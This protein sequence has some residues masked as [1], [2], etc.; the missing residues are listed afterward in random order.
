MCSLVA[1]SF[2]VNSDYDDSSMQIGNIKRRI[3]LSLLRMR[4]SFLSIDFLFC[5]MVVLLG[6]ALK[7]KHLPR[8]KLFDESLLLIPTVIESCQG[9]ANWAG[10]AQKRAEGKRQIIIIGNDVINNTQQQH[11]TLL[12]DAIDTIGASLLLCH[13]YPIVDGTKSEEA[14]ATILSVVVVFVVRR[15]QLLIGIVGFV[16]ILCSL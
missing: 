14:A 11:E 4:V 16:I 8:K 7:Q 5:H 6:R 10:G 15:K 9:S 3:Q 1:P 12:D 2:N 13:T